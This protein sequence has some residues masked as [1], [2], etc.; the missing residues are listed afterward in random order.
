MIKIRKNIIQEQQI[1]QYTLKENRMYS[2][3]NLVGSRTGRMSTT[4]CNTQGL[5][6][7]LRPIIIPEEGYIFLKIDISQAELRIIGD[8]IKKSIYISEKDIHTLT[9]A[10]ITNLDTETFQ[11]LPEYNFYREVAKTLNFGLLYGQEVGGL[12]KSLAREGFYIPYLQCKNFY[13]KWH[14]RYPMIHEYHKFLLENFSETSDGNVFQ[15][16]MQQEQIKHYSTSLD[17]MKNIYENL[18]PLMLNLEIT[19]SIAS[20][21]EELLKSLVNFPVQSTCSEILKLT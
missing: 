21:Q 11:S 4:H 18:E 8:L 17:G 6:H 9:G 2:N 16:Y 5:P 20:S 19:K 12:L 1:G 7:F 10:E 13:E 3:I 14:Q 15:T